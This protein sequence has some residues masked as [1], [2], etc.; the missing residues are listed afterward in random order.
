MANNPRYSSPEV[1]RVAPE[2]SV[3]YCFPTQDESKTAATV[4]VIKDRDS[5]AILARPV[6]RKGRAFEDAVGRAAESARRLGYRGR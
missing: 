6:F 1:D 3:D 4:F 5:R 2:V